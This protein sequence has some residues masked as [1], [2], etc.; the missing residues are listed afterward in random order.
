MRKE[1]QFSADGVTPRGWLF[2]FAGAFSA[3]VP[4]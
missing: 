1:I 2:S 4:A 3:A